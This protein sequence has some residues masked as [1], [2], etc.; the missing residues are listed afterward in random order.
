VL[1]AGSLVAPPAYAALAL[2]RRRPLV[3]S[4]LLKRSARTTYVYF[5]SA[6][7][8]MGTARMWNEPGVA[9]QDRAFRLRANAAQ[10]C[11][12]PLGAMRA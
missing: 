1:Q 12:L 7:I 10:V 3:V 4:E 9:I 11:S 8:L 2:A 6:G 5:G